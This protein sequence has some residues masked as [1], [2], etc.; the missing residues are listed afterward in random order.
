MRLGLGSDLVSEVDH[1]LILSYMD[2]RRETR[3]NQ[4]A[5][6]GAPVRSWGPGWSAQIIYR[7]VITL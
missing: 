1:G 7:F 6:W 5:I 2:E 4:E 3:G